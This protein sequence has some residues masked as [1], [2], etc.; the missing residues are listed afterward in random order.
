MLEQIHELLNKEPFVP[1]RIIL[2]NGDHYDVTSPHMVAMGATQVFYCFPNSD[3]LAW[4][5]VNQITSLETLQQ[6]A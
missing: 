1:F 2:T 6:A 5:R 3:K 4:I